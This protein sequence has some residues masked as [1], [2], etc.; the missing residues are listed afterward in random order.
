[1]SALEDS[2]ANLP[3][4]GQ[5]YSIKRFGVTITN[6]DSEPVH[7]PGCIEGHGVLLVLDPADL[8]MLQVSENT[9]MLLGMAPTALL[10]YPVDLILAADEVLR[11]RTFIDE[12]SL[13][14]NPLYVMTHLGR[15]GAAPL[16]VSVHYVKDDGIGIA[17]EHV[18]HVFKMFK[19]LHGR[20]DYGGGSGAGLTIVKKLVER[21]GGTVWLT[22]VPGQGTT[23][24]FSLPAQPAR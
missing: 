15:D 8:T 17:P 11:L 13:E 18:D 4:K 12:M 14:R 7:T 16:D 19:R 5:P 24:Y 6:C 1:M 3:W 21:H 2:T 10:G 22:S 23:F 9:K 20:D